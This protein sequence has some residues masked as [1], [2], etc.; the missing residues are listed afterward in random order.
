MGADL[1]LQLVQAVDDASGY[2]MVLQVAELYALEGEPRLMEGEV[3]VGYG[4]GSKQM[5]VPTA[6]INPEVRLGLGLGLGLRLGLG[7]GLVF[8]SSRLCS[9][10]ARIGARGSK[11]RCLHVDNLHV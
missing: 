2:C 8:S 3:V 7:L 5:G 10:C 4:R 9:P 11:A 1:P 6:N